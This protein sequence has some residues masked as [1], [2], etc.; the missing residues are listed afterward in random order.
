MM[1][2]V[3]IV[4]LLTVSVF[5]MGSCAKKGETGQSGY[6]SVTKF[7]PARDAAKDI[8]AAIAEA[9]NSGRRVLLDVGGEWCSWCHLLDR[10]FDDNADIKRF[11]HENYV[12]LKINYSKE[13]KNEEILSKYPPIPGYPHFFVLDTDGEFLYSQDTG[14]LE[15]GD[16]HDREKVYE[17]LKTWA[18]P[19][20]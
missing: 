8:Q 20:K 5:M 14:A 1:T 19:K 16:H 17:F 2:K 7:D 10:F 18:P 11:M 15:S 4:F 6:I 12:V 3:A 9:R 13:N